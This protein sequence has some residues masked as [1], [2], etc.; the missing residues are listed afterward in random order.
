MTND[1]VENTAIH[2]A[3]RRC[4]MTPDEV[5]SMALAAVGKI[6]CFLSKEM[7]KFTDRLAADVAVAVIN[8]TLGCVQA[9]YYRLATIYILEV[10]YHRYRQTVNVNSPYYFGTAEISERLALLKHR[11]LGF[12]PEDFK[13]HILKLVINGKSEL[14]EMPK[15][16]FR[17]LKAML[18]TQSCPFTIEDGS[19]DYIARPRIVPRNC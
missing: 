19:N 2:A 18:E 16:Q 11:T 7:C 3:L 13:H 8:A 17:L 5:V 14:E 10:N 6:E 4:G 9:R 15:L 12:M 1:T